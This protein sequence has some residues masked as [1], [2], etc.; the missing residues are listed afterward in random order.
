MKKNISKN[1]KSVSKNNYDIELLK[2]MHKK[3]LL[4]RDLKKKPANYMVWAK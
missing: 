2:K 4:I 3:M 1:S